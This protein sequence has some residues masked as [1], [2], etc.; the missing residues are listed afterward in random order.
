MFTCYYGTSQCR[1]RHESVYWVAPDAEEWP[2]RVRHIPRPLNDR[3][4]GNVCPATVAPAPHR[5][6]FIA[7]HTVRARS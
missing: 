7:N 4:R 1:A 3:S 2:A 5:W 6:P